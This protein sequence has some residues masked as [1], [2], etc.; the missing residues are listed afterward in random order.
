[1]VLRRAAHEFSPDQASDHFMGLV[2]AATRV[3]LPGEDLLIYGGEVDA[4]FAEVAAFVTGE[5]RPPAPE[6]IVAAVLYSDLVA[7]TDHR[8]V[9]RR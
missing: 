3:D 8:V 6:R 5:H 7:S 9:P 1:L 4:L 2:P